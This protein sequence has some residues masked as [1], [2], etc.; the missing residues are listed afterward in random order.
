[1]HGLGG[2]PGSLKEQ[3]EDLLRC[4]GSQTSLIGI[5][6]HPERRARREIPI[7]RDGSLTETHFIALFGISRQPSMRHI[8]GAKH[9]G[10]LVSMLLDL[11][12]VC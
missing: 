1:M 6:R 5:D 2:Q 3:V 11:A 4:L 8:E 10:S 7:V 12:N 9:Q